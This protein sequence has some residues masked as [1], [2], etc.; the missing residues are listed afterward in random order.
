VEQ[1]LFAVAGVEIF[2]PAPGMLRAGVGTGVFDQ[3]EPK[4]E[5]EPHKNQPS[6]KQQVITE[7]ASLLAVSTLLHELIIPERE[8]T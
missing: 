5:P 4:P 6:P 7:N 1:Q 2:W 8:I 3:L